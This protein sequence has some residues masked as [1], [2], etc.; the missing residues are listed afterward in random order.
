MS[1]LERFVAYISRASCRSSVEGSSRV[2]E[3]RSMTGPS[4]EPVQAS[5]RFPCACEACSAKDA[6]LEACSEAACSRSL[7][8]RDDRKIRSNPFGDS[9]SPVQDSESTVFKGVL[10]FSTLASER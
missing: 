8:V 4:K 10:D 3:A 9:F 6:L 2:T 5:V 7:V 1:Y